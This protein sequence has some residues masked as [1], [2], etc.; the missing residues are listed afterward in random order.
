MGASFFATIGSKCKLPACSSSKGAQRIPLVCLIMKATASGVALLAA[1][2]KSPSFSRSSSSATTIISPAAMAFKASSTV[3][4]SAFIFLLTSYQKAC[5]TNTK[6]RTTHNYMASTSLNS[7]ISLLLS[8]SISSKT[9]L[10]S[11]P[12]S[13]T[14]FKGG[15]D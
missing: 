9:S 15:G 2:I 12:R 7:S 8:P 14:A 3:S 4:N 1:M 5:E 10:V 6:Q 11:W 13:G